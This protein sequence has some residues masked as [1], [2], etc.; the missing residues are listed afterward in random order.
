M[1]Q[2]PRRPTAACIANIEVDEG[3][4]TLS[5]GSTDPVSSDPSPEAHS[6]AP[7]AAAVGAASSDGPVCWP[8]ASIACVRMPTTSGP[9]RPPTA[10][11]MLSTAS[12]TTAACLFS[13]TFG[14]VKRRPPTAHRN[15]L[16]VQRRTRGVTRESVPS[17]LVARVR[18]A[19][20]MIIAV[21]ECHRLSVRD[22]AF[23][24][25]RFCRSQHA[26]EASH[27]RSNVPIRPQRWGSAEIR[28]T[29]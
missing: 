17:V 9:M 29:S 5:S 23:A 14:H 1:A 3:A 22:T 20:P 25:I 12:A 8:A 18:A 26:W 28:A 11:A 13:H 19:P 6:G 21:A 27:P 16:A 24:A 15:P 2:P 7:V 10:L 4:P